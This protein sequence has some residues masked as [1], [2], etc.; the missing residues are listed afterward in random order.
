[1]RVP[2]LAHELANNFRFGYGTTYKILQQHD[3]DTLQ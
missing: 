1:M 3:C 2:D